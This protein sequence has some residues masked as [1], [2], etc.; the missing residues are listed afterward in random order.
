MVMFTY[1]KN[2][3]KNCLIIQFRSRF[4]EYV[5]F[6]LNEIG[7][8]NNLNIWSVVSSHRYLILLKKTITI[9]KLSRKVSLWME[10]KFESWCCCSQNYLR[11]LYKRVGESSIIRNIEEKFITSFKRTP[12]N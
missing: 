8:K 7:Y 1:I 2:E 9:F 10:Y 5:P 12:K 3:F 6:Y 4:R 11:S